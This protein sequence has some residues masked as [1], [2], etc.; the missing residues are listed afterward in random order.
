M[1]HGSIDEKVRKHQRRLQNDRS[2]TVWLCQPVPAL[3]MVKALKAVSEL[4]SAPRAEEPWL[5]LP[6]KIQPLGTASELPLSQ[7]A[8][9]YELPLL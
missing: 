8:K 9:I 6:Q 5:L 2:I 4:V 7:S 3:C 1:L